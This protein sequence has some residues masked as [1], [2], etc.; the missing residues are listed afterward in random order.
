MS[1]SE[2]PF[3]DGL[4]VAELHMDDSRASAINLYRAAWVVLNGMSL[5]PLS[6]LLDEESYCYGCRS[7]E[8]FSSLAGRI[9][10]E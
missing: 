1:P 4:L 5:F 2:E 8:G 7:R 6:Q 10:Q 9:A 3:C